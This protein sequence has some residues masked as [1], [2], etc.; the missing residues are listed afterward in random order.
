M[1][2]IADNEPFF[3]TEHEFVAMA[4]F[5]QGDSSARSL[6]AL[7]LVEVA[8]PEMGRAGLQTLL[9]RDLAHIDDEQI[10]LDGPA[11]VVASILLT[12]YEWNILTIDGPN[13]ASV[14]VVIGAAAGKLLVGVNPSGVHEVR[15]LNP[16]LVP[17]AV[18][19]DLAVAAA[20]DPNLEGG[21][22]VRVRR[23]AG[24]TEELGV[25]AE[26]L[27]DGRWR[28]GE[29]LLN[30]ATGPLAELWPLLTDRLTTAGERES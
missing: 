11:H 29:G 26:R 23:L 20:S 12:S 5:E 24:P 30:S 3:L 10:T 9:V 18:V 17:L 4:G 27:A 14:I 21:L 2:V 13:V 25:R 6:D 19:G 1:S 7:G 8:T 15:P 22:V 16:E 28:F